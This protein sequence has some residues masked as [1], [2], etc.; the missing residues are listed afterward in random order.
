M[1][2]RVEIKEESLLESALHGR[3]ELFKSDEI[4][5]ARFFLRL[6]TPTKFDPLEPPRDTPV[7]WPCIECP[8]FVDLATSDDDASG[9]FGPF[10][11]D[12]GAQPRL[13]VI[14][15]RNH[16]FPKRINGECGLT[17]IP[18][19]EPTVSRLPLKQRVQV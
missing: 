18:G 17:V 8:L 15:H 2:F 1:S 13:S 12:R 6:D 3:I 14:E 9:C 11:P 10:V 5:G 7:V 16:T 4:N 19:T